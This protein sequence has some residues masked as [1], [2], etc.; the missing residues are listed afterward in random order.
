MDYRTTLLVI[1][2]AASLSACGGTP[3]PYPEDNGVDLTMQQV[4]LAETT[5]GV[6]RTP[7]SLA[8]DVYRAYDGAGYVWL[9]DTSDNST[10]RSFLLFSLATIPGGAEI[11]SATLTVGMIRPLGTPF[12]DLGDLLVERVDTG[13]AIDDSD[14]ASAGQF[15]GRFGLGAG[16]HDIDVTEALQAA[17]PEAAV[18]FRVGFQSQTDGDRDT[19]I[20]FMNDAADTA[21]KVD[22]DL[23]VPTLTIVYRVR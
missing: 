1:L 23:S 14:Y 11:E 18:D 17:L 6:S 2:M 20:A 15:A 12:A 8:P 21:A 3:R 19:D 7:Q 10:Y 5:G 16:D 13:G 9:G 4:L 22:L